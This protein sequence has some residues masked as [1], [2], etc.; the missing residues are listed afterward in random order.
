MKTIPVLAHR[1]RNPGCCALLM[2]MSIVSCRSVG[3]YPIP[4]FR[5][6][7][8][9]TRLVTLRNYPGCYLLQT[10]SDCDYVE[11]DGAG[12]VDLSSLAEDTVVL[13]CTVRFLDA[14]AGG[15]V[16]GVDGPL[17]TRVFWNNVICCS[18][19]P[20]KNTVSAPQPVTTGANLLQVKSCRPKDGKWRILL[21]PMRADG[22]PLKLKKHFF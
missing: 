14:Q 4:E 3:N 17:G 5:A 11:V 10:G 1:M 2:L 8:D 9:T 13:S 19:T 20:G 18:A 22:S 12:W 15:V 16:L 21:R 6:I 7:A